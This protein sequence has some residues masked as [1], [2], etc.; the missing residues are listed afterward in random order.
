MRLKCCSWLILINWGIYQLLDLGPAIMIQNSW[1]AC[2]FLFR[3]FC[4]NL[5]KIY[6]KYYKIVCLWDCSRR[7]GRSPSPAVLAACTRSNPALSGN[8][9]LQSTYMSLKPC[10]TVVPYRGYNQHILWNVSDYDQLLHTFMQHMTHTGL[11]FLRGDV[12]L[13][14]LCILLQ[15]KPNIK[16]EKRSWPSEPSSTVQSKTL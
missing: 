2:K 16:L 10:L 9:G 15:I 5:Y 6:T 3:D 1:L 7:D 11:V 13:L 8:L 4:D 12:Y 14:L